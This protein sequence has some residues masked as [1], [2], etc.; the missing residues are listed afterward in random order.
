MH[1]A[2]HGLVPSEYFSRIHMCFWYLF[3]M[4]E[5]V[6]TEETATV[7]LYCYGVV[8]FS[9]SLVLLH[10]LAVPVLM[11]VTFHE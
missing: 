10:R 2:F 9:V 1:T 5:V 3:S 6:I 11:T 8:G 4:K 7:A